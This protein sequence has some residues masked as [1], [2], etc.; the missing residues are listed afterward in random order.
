MTISDYYYA[1]MMPVEKFLTSQ[2]IDYVLHEHPAVYTCEQAR[3]YCAHIP[4][5]ACKNLLLMS[6]KSEKYFLII[7]PAEKRADMKHIARILDEKQLAFADPAALKNKLGLEPGAVSPFG[8]LNDT[9]HEIEV[10][11]DKEVHEADILSFHPNRNTASLELSKNMFRKFL[12]IIKNK[13][14]IDNQ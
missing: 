3:K 5:L 14:I 10:Y 9:K 6:R 13:I 2:H 11:I 4:G 12:Q 8:L 7:L 1:I